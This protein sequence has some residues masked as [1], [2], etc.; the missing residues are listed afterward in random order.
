MTRN[1]TTVP[2]ADHK[3]YI[4]RSLSLA[5]DHF[6]WWYSNLIKI[7]RRPLKEAHQFVRSLSFR[8]FKKLCLLDGWRP[9]PPLSILQLWWVP[10]VFDCHYNERLAP[11]WCRACVPF[12]V[13]PATNNTLCL[14]RALRRPHIMQ[15]LASRAT[16]HAASGK[17]S[18]FAA[19][20]WQRQCR[21]LSSSSICTSRQA[22]ITVH[23]TASC[24]SFST[25]NILHGWL[26]C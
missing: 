17:P 7:F 4:S 25:Q 13:A 11:C 14:A 9:L 15:R 6:H 10:A 5:L 16:G 3:P 23:T 21:S 8:A 26:P 19:C 12:F 24:C 1:P 20:C 18:A 22:L 2:Y